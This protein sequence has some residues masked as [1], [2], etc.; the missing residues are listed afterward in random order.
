MSEF[1]AID[2][3][4]LS[5]TGDRAIESDS[6]ANQRRVIED[7]VKNHPE[8]ELV[9]EKIDDGWSGIL[10]D[11][12]RFNEM[13]ELIKEG[14]VN[15]V[16]V[17][18][19][20]RLGRD[21]IETGRHLQRIF[22]AYGVRFIA[23]NDDIDTMR[24]GVKGN[25]AV[26]FK[27][28]VNDAYSHDISVKT[29]SSLAVK[30][31]NGDFLGACTVYGYAKA[32]DNKNQLVIDETA[33]AVVRDIFR[34]KQEGNSAARIAEDL[35][36][37]GV[38]SPM[39]YKRENGI[40]HPTGGYAD[41]ADCKWS[42]TTIIRILKDET[43]TGVLT[44]GKQ[45]T[46]NYKIKTV[47]KRPESEW[48]RT[49]NAHEAII[50]KHDFDLVQRILN[51]DTRTAPGEDKVYLFSGILIC[52][53]CG[54]RM[55]RKTVTYKGQKY[56]YYYCP[57]GK[58]HGCHAPMLKESDLTDS[59]L[60]SLQSHINNIVSLDALL[61]ACGTAK[62]NQ[63][64]INQHMDQIAQNERR[65]AV[66]RGYKSTLY[67]NMV[68][69]NINKPEYMSMKARYDEIINQ[70]EE[71]NDSIEQEMEALRNNTSERL[72][73]ME[74]FKKFESLNGLDRRVV[75]GLIQSVVV[76]SKTDIEITYNYQV[77]YEQAAEMAT[78]EFV[79]KEAV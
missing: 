54:G 37:L 58:K 33:A 56:F 53:C 62:L 75:I 68:S 49:E 36:R 29:R 50:R 42:A 74:H 28:L 15:C 9:D 43:Y 79:M 11:R 72:K 12:P 13:M 6:I 35:N 19:L 59:I 71:A 21:Y 47:V 7:Y 14:K 78:K 64:L 67:E 66:N 17:K 57:A 10:F 38:L 40:P 55:T 23:I 65:I 73:W 39:E 77:E 51:L 18:D 32:P 16:I 69:G 22:P 5:Y 20:S 30:R 70:L 31:G 60:G 1:K 63:T 3:L 34:S 46:P 44:Q 48:V 4:R 24:E 52:G 27:S 45:G 26:S 41:K 2:Y 61:N 25:M 76:Q 8:I